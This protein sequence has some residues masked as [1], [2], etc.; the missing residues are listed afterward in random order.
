L[1]L[2]SGMM[3]QSLVQGLLK[4][5]EVAIKLI[6]NHVVIASNILQ[7]AKNISSLFERCTPE[8]CNVTD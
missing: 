3:S 8:F 6:K 2:G 7:D 5:K 1:I 4:R